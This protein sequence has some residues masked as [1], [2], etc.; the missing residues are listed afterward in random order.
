VPFALLGLVAKLMEASFLATVVLILLKGAPHG[1]EEVTFPEQFVASGCLLG[2]VKHKVCLVMERT[3][4]WAN[5]LAIGDKPDPAG[6][7]QILHRCLK[8]THGLVEPQC[9]YPLPRTQL[10]WVKLVLVF[11]SAQMHRSG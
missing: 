1:L 5:L 9:G 6:V 8:T 7:R 10:G 2:L 3:S 4:F 11:H